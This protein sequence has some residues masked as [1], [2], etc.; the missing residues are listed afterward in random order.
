[1]ARRQDSGEVVAP[2]TSPANVGG[3]REAVRER[4]QAQSSGEEERTEW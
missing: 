4:W 1:M 2:S 3:R